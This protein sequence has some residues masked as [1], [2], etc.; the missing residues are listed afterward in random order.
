MDARTKQLDEVWRVAV[1]RLKGQNLELAETP[2]PLKMGSLRMYLQALK[3]MFLGRRYSRA[4]KNDDTEY[5]LGQIER[6]FGKPMLTFALSALDQHIRYYNALERG[7]LVGAR[8]IH[9]RWEAKSHL[10]ARFPK[11]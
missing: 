8:E 2:G 1:A 3:E 5:F 6:Q 9:Q 11:R 7:N 4:M 10:A